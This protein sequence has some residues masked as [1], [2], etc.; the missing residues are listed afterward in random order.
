[1]TPMRQVSREVVLSAGLAALVAMLAALT[2][3]CSTESRAQSR[4]EEK[5]RPANAAPAAQVVDPYKASL[6]F[7]RCMRQHGVPHPDPDRGGNFHLTPREERLM[8]RA[9]RRQHEAAEKACFHHLK[10]VVSTKPLSRR[11]KAL[12]T[13]ALEDFSRCMRGHGYDFYR[14]PTV[15]NL[16]RGRA[17]FGFSRT[18]PAITRAQRTTRFLRAR[19]SCEK[20]LNAKLDDIIATDRGEVQY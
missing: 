16:S 1:M 11:A 14:D 17:F 3:G 4:D 12:A 9:G 20:A 8:R 15:R 13:R 2:A 7:A 10:P 19:T 18:D 5:T 6:A